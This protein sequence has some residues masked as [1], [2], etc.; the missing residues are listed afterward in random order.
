MFDDDCANDFIQ[1]AGPRGGPI[2]VCGNSSYQGTSKFAWMKLSL[3]TNGSI[4]INDF[5]FQ[6]KCKVPFIMHKMYMFVIRFYN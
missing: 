6:I 4:K 2:R 3:V 1:V 5:F